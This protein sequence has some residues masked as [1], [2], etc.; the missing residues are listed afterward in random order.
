MVLAKRTRVMCLVLAAAVCVTHGSVFTPEQT[1]S[2]LEFVDNLMQC[3]GIVGLSMAVVRGNDTWTRGFGLADRET[4]RTVSSSTLFGIG[5][6]TK[7]FTSAILSLFINETGKYAWTTPVS[8]ILGEDFAFIDDQ[9]TRHVTIKDLLTHR[10]GLQAT[11][12]PLFANLPNGMTPDQFAQRLKYLPVAAPFRDKFEYNNW[13]YGLAGRIIEVMGGAS[14]E[15]L[16]RTRLFEPLGM[17]DSRVLG[18][19]VTVQASNFAK[20]YVQVGDD[21]VPSDPSIYSISPQEPAGAIASSADDM[22][23][24]LL[25]FNNK[26]KTLE[27]DTVLNDTRMREMLTPSMGLSMSM[28]SRVN[29]WKP[30]FPVT[31]NTYGYGYGWM[32]GTY[33]GYPVT[34]HSGGIYAYTTYLL[35]L[36]TL[37]LGVYVSSSGPGG[38]NSSLIARQILFHVADLALGLQPWLNLSNACEFPQLWAANNDSSASD[39][40]DAVTILGEQF[41]QA[42]DFSGTYGHLLFGDVKVEVTVNGSTGGRGL[43]ARFNRLQGRLLRT[44]HERVAMLEVQGG[45]A[46]LSQLPNATH[47]MNLTFS[48]P[49][50]D[51]RYQVLL[52]SAPD[53]GEMDTLLFE[54]GVK[55]TDNG[56]SGARGVLAHGAGLLVV[57]SAACFSHVFFALLFVRHCFER[58]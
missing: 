50:H 42:E 4:G 5:S 21:V 53:M 58:S 7:A 57:S 8:D 27:G 2:L 28:S 14:W 24:W 36:P 26:G 18:R 51:G 35:L 25:L 23:K 38:G 54:R 41:D 37:D 17:T 20:P 48:S 10:T 45:L 52:L 49:S 16:L 1:T 55:Y 22:A 29:V 34:W 6:V 19:T 3:R 46:F 12:I 32:V 31:F 9:L 39:P 33:R 40:E 43:A 11:N 30:I 15:E 47:Y 44:D 13:M 56:A